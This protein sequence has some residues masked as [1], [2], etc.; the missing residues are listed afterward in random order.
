LNQ[1]ARGETG[2]IENGERREIERKTIQAAKIIQ[3]QKTLLP[4]Y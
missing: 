3:K 2:C 1:K 4:P